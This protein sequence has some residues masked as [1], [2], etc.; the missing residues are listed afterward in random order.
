[1][2]LHSKNS[3]KIYALHGFLGL[4]SDWDP[5]KFVDKPLQL[6]NEQLDFWDWAAK[7]N[8]KNS[9]KETKK[10]LVGYSL[11]GRLAMHALLENPDNWFGAILI[12]AH[13]GLD[14]NQDKEA[15]L[16]NDRRWAQRFLNDPWE[17]LMADWNKNPVFQNL[18]FPFPREEHLFN[19]KILAEQLIRWSLGK[20]ESL[21]LRLKNLKIPLMFMVGTLDTKFCELAKK[22]TSSFQ[23]SMIPEAAHRV[24]W[25]Q[26]KLFEEQVTKFIEEIT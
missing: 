16:E 8:R 25:D 20:Q 18:A 4:P 1:M 2:N 13:P 9:N 12:S 11:G 6:E 26:P 21:A 24:P 19:R 23:V 14:L 5:F 3:Y 17:L 10:I 15:R 7:F 22:F